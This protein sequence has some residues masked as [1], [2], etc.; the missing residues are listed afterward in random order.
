M[1]NRCGS[2]E[3]PDDGILFLLK[4]NDFDKSVLFL[5]LGLRLSICCIIL[6]IA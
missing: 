5:F 6:M 1:Q 4:N 3:K 2:T